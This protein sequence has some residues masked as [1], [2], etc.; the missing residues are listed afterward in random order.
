MCLIST[1]D[2]RQHREDNDGYCA[3]CEEWTG[4]F[5]EFDAS[6]DECPDCGEFT[7]YGCEEALVMGLID[8]E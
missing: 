1:E 7:V 8:I 3:T 6:G 5:C 2:F 4:E